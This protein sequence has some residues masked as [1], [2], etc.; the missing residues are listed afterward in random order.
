M[1]SWWKG[2]GHIVQEK[3]PNGGGNIGK[4]VVRVQQQHL[5]TWEEEGLNRGGKKCESRHRKTGSGIRSW[6]RCLL[7]REF[8]G[9]CWKRE[10]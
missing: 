2:F 7:K 3:T 5:G 6:E 4:M 10:E 8:E 1:L 9:C